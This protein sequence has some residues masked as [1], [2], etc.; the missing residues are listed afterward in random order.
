MVIIGTIIMMTWHKWGI[1]DNSD[2]GVMIVMTMM[3]T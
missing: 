1:K 2:T 3:M